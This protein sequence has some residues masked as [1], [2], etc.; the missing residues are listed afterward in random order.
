MEFVYYIKSAFYFVETLHSLSVETFLAKYNIP[1]LDHPPY[2]PDPAFY[3]LEKEK[4]TLTR[5]TFQT[6]EHIKK[7]ETHH[8]RAHRRRLGIYILT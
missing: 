5:T 8:E 2:F 4:P 1:L 6:L 7:N 3:L